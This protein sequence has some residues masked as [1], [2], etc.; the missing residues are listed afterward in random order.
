MTNT[1]NDQDSGQLSNQPAEKTDDSPKEKVF[2]G[3]SPAEL[4][5]IGG[6]NYHGSGDHYRR[7][8]NL[9]FKAAMITNE[10]M[11]A[12][13]HPFA[14]DTDQRGETNDVQQRSE[15][16]DS[17][18]DANSIENPAL[19]DPGDGDTATP[20]DSYEHQQTKPKAPQLHGDESGGGDSDAPPASK[21]SNTSQQ[22]PKL[23]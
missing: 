2:V 22:K 16:G 3:L 5:E 18:L 21:D 13:T 20:D 6:E 12:G 4:E 10:N 17:D 15:D 14:P 9:D 11:T 19:D 1:P 7:D 8:D 23:G